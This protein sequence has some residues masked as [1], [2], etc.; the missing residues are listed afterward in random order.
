M[1]CFLMTCHRTAGYAFR[2]MAIVT[3]TV[4]FLQATPVWAQSDFYKNPPSLMADIKKGALPAIEERLPQT[5]LIVQPNE[6]LGQ[7]GGVWRLGMK[8]NSDRAMVYRTIGYEHLVRWDPGWTRVIPNV[9]LSYTVNDDATEFTFRL[10]P[11]LKW[12]DGYPFTADDIMFWYEAVL[13]NKELTPTPISKYVVDDKLVRVSK[14]DVYTVRFKFAAPNGLFLKTLASG[15]DSGGPV[16]FPRHWL[17]RYHKDYNPAGIAAEV[18]RAGAKDWVEL[19]LLKSGDDRI[20]KALPHLMRQRMNSDFAQKDFEP[21]PTL[22]GW[23]IQG[24]AGKDPGKIVATRNPYY[25]KI[26]PAGKQLPYIDRVEYHTFKGRDPIRAMALEGRIGMQARRLTDPKSQLVITAPEATGKFR[27]FSLIATETNDI[28]IALNLSHP[29]PAKRALFNRLEF[30]VALS[31]AINRKAIIRE[32]YDGIGQPYQVGPRPESRFYNERLATQYMEFDILKAEKLLA[33]IGLK[34][35][36]DGGLVGPDGDIVA[37]KVMVREDHPHKQTAMNMIIKSWRALG[38]QV[39]MEVLPRADMEG[40]IRS[41]Q[42]DA[43][44]TISD[45]GLQP[46]LAPSAYMPWSFESAFG[47]GWVN[48]FANPN[49]ARAVEPPEWAKKQMTLYRKILA[50]GDQEMQADLM[51]QILEITAEQFPVMGVTLKTEKKG[52]VGNRFFN[53]PRA[54]IKSWT[55]PTPAPTNPSQYFVDP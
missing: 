29:D 5:P 33:S 24:T 40:R 15:R 35:R 48:W 26:D 23:V 36:T 8:G 3:G 31:H 55:Y 27:L 12:S 49:N 16:D 4:C 25:F 43:T 14:I 39:D 18:T 45:G 32:I 41:N 9:A 50:S 22:N 20:P 30:R 1:S 37:F 17:K 7:Y 42:F 21:W 2:V 19:F 38:L 44:F 51:Q 54:I 10:R 6:R 28:P 53:V 52:V 13:S 46:D 34:K 47:I 11:G